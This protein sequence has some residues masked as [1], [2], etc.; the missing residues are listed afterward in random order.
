MRNR[1]LTESERN[2]PQPSPVLDYVWYPSASAD[3]PATYCFVA[4][5]RECPV[6]LLDASTGRV[7]CSRYP[8]DSTHLDALLGGG[9]FALASCFV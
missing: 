2:F 7:S 3:N 1:A 5:V 9:G 8:E 6:K 4:S